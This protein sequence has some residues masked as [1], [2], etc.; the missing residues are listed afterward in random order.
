MSYTQKKKDL[1]AKGMPNPKVG[2]NVT[3]GDKKAELGIKLR[4]GRGREGSMEH[5]ATGLHNTR[6]LL[7]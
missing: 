5:K 3:S 7:D 2:K 6:A 1:A 4:K